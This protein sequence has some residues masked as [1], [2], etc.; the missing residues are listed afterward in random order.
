ME[1][2]SGLPAWI[3]VLMLIMVML[4]MTMIMKLMLRMMIMMRIK[5]MRMKIMSFKQI[6]Y[7]EDFQTVRSFY[8]H[9][10]PPQRPSGV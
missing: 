1:S 9:S 8:T 7:D 5:I 2:L 6:R 10:T 4:M 3:M